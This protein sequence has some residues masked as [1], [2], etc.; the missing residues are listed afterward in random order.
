MQT[1]D[2]EKLLEAQQELP[3]LDFK[4]PMGWD[5]KSF[6]PHFLAMANE[7]DGGFIIVGVE[8]NKATPGN[9]YVR[10]GVD[11][12]TARSYDFDTMK[13]QLSEYA[14]P[15]VDF[16]LFKPLGTDGQRY[17][18]IKVLEFDFLPII[19]KKDC[20]KVDGGKIYGRK[21]D[22]KPQSAPISNSHQMR[23]LIDRATVKMMQHYQ[24]LGLVAPSQ[25]TD[26]KRFDDEAKD[27]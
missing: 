13:D 26:V 15:H 2:L 21:H 3:G 12:V 19:S 18:V 11:E 25:P 8:E 14:D 6:A 10:R 1:K 5:V 27:F 4:G 7:R 9:P 24:R 23:E 20:R 16:Q 22:K 17:V